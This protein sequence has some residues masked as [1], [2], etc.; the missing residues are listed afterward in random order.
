[1]MAEVDKS[2]CCKGAHAPLSLLMAACGQCCTVV[3]TTTGEIW[4]CGTL[5]TD[6]DAQ[7]VPWGAVGGEGCG[8]DHGPRP[9][10]LGGPNEFG[11]CALSVAARTS[12]AAAVMADGGLWTWGDGDSGQLGHGDTEHRLVPT[13]L[14]E[15][16]FG[17]VPVVGVACGLKCTFALVEDGGIFSWG[18]GCAGTLGHGDCLDKMTPT[19]ICGL[20]AH[21]CSIFAGELHAGAISAEGDLWTW[22]VGSNGRLGLGDEGDHPAPMK[23][24]REHF[25]ASRVVVAAAGEGHSVAVCGDGSMYAWGKAADGRLGLGKD[26]REDQLTPVCVGCEE[27]FGRLV[28]C[29]CGSKHTLA[30]SEEG[31]L[32][33]WGRGTGGRLGLADRN[34]RH[35]PTHVQ[36]LKNKVVL[37]VAGSTHSVAISEHGCML[38]WGQASLI[39]ANG[40]EKPAGLGH[41]DLEDKLV[42]AKVP[43]PEGVRV[44]GGGI[45][46]P[47]TH[48]LAFAMCLHSRLGQGCVCADLKEDL[49]RRICR[50]GGAF[51]VP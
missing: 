19:R 13:R 10:R 49:V 41:A 26:V 44:G 31:K 43:L 8:L 47:R 29:A 2:L 30:V 24:G 18:S 17:R 38:S 4:M 11:S 51:F 36:T 35:T 20:I 21:V 34:K 32:W 37:A 39:V 14:C 3:V 12:H 7:L 50:N 22:G 45:V 40:I 1:M 28:W 9:E 15:D 5:V 23:I 6:K 42:P 27:T 48:V 46:L 16:L 33:A 25:G